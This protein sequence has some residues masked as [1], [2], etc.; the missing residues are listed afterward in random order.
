MSSTRK[1]TLP[2]LAE[3]SPL[4]KAAIAAGD[5]HF[6]S[7]AFNVMDHFKDKTTEEIRQTL[8]DT[9][10]PCAVAFENWVGSFTVSSGIRNCNAFNVKEVFYLGVKRLDRRGMLGVQNYTDIQWLSTIGEFVA[11]KNKYVFVGVDNI[12]GSV[13]LPTYD[14]LPNSLMIFGSE[15]VGLTPEMQAMCQH[16]VSIPQRGSIRSLNAAVASGIV[17]Y[18]YST[19]VKQ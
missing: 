16:I 7:S 14:W 9:A 2:N 19:K 15:G 3:K 17:L 13:P 11:L 6:Y 8:K 4:H 10:L 18:D 1:T 5:E 12:P